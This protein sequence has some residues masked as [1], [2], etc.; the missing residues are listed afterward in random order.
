METK[1]RQ[2]GLALGDLYVAITAGVTPQAIAD[3]LREITQL[4]KKL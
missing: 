1:K 4:L 3:R 2:L